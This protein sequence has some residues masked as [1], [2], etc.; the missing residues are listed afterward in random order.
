MATYGVH[1][2]VGRLRKV[3]VHRPDLSLKRLTPA[4]AHE[5]LFDD[6]LWVKKARWEHDVF[7][8]QMR[9]RDIEVLLVGDLLTETLRD[10]EARA[11]LLNSK[12]TPNELG[13]TLSQELRAWLN[14]MDA[15]A[16]ATYLTGGLTFR[17]LPRA[18][19]AM[20]V[21]ISQPTDFVLFPLPNQLFTRDTSCWIYSGVT[22]NPMYWPARRQETLNIAA[23]YRF[24]PAFKDADFKY[25]YGEDV[26]QDHGKA[27]V[28]GGDVMPIGN[29]TVVIGMGERTTPQAIGQIARNLFVRGGAE[30]V[31]AARLPRDRAHMHLDTVFT[32]CDRDVVTVFAPVV[33]RIQTFSIQPGN[34]EGEIAVTREERPF[35]DVVAAALGLKHLRQVPTGGDEFEAEREQ[36]DDGNNVLA[37]EPGVVVA[38]E[39]ND[40]TNTR[41]RQ[42]GIE[43]IT[44]S[45]S[46]LGRGRGGSHC[47]A[48]P[49]L[50]DPV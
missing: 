25:W 11:W 8:D 47:M 44:I 34:M 19:T 28:E 43:V 26:D 15:P 13:L 46:E 17:E 36:W 27:H 24:H 3:L 37:L 35:I 2:E 20:E 39:R 49:L 14:E 42:A 18:F 5:L 30:C 38:Y 1:S 45:G 31:I 4:N 16:L 50:R 33:E 9:S 41:L 48:C 23:I 12:V 40:D 29:K 32:F 6:V 7:V 22:L 10:P 21:M